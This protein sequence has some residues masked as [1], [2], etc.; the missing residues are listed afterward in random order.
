MGVDLEFKA[1]GRAVN[2]PASERLTK[3]VFVCGCLEMELR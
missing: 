1:F 2:I 3:C